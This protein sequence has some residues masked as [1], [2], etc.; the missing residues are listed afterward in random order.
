ME[1]VS[2]T[3]LNTII[4]KHGPL[5]ELVIQSFTRQIT[6]GLEHLHSKNISHR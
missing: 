1:F 4:Q 6:E 2:G 3:T 5:T